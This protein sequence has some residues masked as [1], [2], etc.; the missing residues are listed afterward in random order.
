MAKQKQILWDKRVMWAIS[1]LLIILII[2]YFV[3]RGSNTWFL[4]RG[5]DIEQ[6][7]GQLFENAIHRQYNADTP[8][9]KHTGG[10]A[11]FERADLLDIRSAMQINDNRPL[12]FLDLREMVRIDEEDLNEVLKDKGILEGHGDSFLLAQ[13][14]HNVNVFYLVAHA[15]V[16]TGHGNSELASGIEYEDETYYNFFGIGA[17]DSGAVREGHS[18]AVNEEWTSPEA[19]I[20]GGAKFISENY[21]KNDQFTTYA[22]RWNPD[23][24]T[25]NQYATD[26]NWSRV[27]AEITESYYDYFEIEPR[28][29]YKN[30]YNE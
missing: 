3:S 6:F 24:P 27:I 17:F 25:R 10:P 13:R 22:M 23:N 15:L 14:R 4:D 29:F 19:A 1:A 2:A 11:L 20:L 18:Y 9:M 12:E 5:E 21:I 16:E 8:P 30:F 7:Q 26:V 28:R